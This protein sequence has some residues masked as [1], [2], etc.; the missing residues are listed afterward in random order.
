MKKIILIVGIILFLGVGG[1]LIF[2]QQPS[3]PE[4]KSY[5]N[6]GYSFQVLYPGDWVV[7]EESKESGSFRLN[8]FHPEDINN[9]K[10]YGN[11]AITFIPAENPEELL[12]KLLP[13]IQRDLTLDTKETTIGRLSGLQGTA[14]Q[15]ALSA[16]SLFIHGLFL[17]TQK[18]GVFQI[19]GWAVELA[20]GK[21]KYQ[22]AIQDIVSSIQFP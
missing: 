16:E 12:N 1:Y 19:N 10:I 20:S 15:E 9:A 8:I 11:V 18:G 2:L 6:E 7:K 21:K 4:W 5:V 17:D 3:D 22:T 13:L 14:Y